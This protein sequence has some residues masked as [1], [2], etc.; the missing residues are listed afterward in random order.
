MIPREQQAAALAAAGYTP[1]QIA[2]ILEGR[3]S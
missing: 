3:C 1:R 2:A